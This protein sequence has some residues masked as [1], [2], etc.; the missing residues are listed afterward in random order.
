MMT[1]QDRT[2]SLNH[3]TPKSARVLAGVQLAKGGDL[4]RYYPLSAEAEEEY[5]TWKT[6][7]A[8]SLGQAQ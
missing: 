6:E 8:Q 3:D 5:E 2:T 4:R 7:R 1:L